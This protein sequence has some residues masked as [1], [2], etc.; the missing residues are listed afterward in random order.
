MSK[1][2]AFE[3]CRVEAENIADFL[4]RYYKPERYQDRG[5]EYMACLLASHEND[6]L[7]YGYDIISRYDSVTGRVVAYFGKAQSQ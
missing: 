1:R 7:R 4:Q 5:E 6:L 2:M 3:D